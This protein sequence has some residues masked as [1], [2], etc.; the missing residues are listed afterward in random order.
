MYIYDCIHSAARIKGSVCLNMRL[1][2]CLVYNE[3]GIVVN[4]SITYW[5]MNVAFE[6][7]IIVKK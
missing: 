2:Y 6:E 4:C 3:I 5:N 7:T 1:I